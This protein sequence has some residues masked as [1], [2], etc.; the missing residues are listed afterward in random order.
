MRQ[1]RWMDEHWLTDD[2]KTLK[3][4]LPEGW[5]DKAH[6][7]GAFVRPRKIKNPEQLLRLLLLHVAPGLSLRNAVARAALS[8]LPGITDVALLGRFREAQG[9]LQC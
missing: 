9:W 3:A 2:W 6:E 1:E 7:T 5:E 4:L 8:G